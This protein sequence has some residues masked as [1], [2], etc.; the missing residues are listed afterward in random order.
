MKQFVA[1]QKINLIEWKVKTKK[2]RQKQ[3]FNKNQ[4]FP[5]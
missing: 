4:G 1:I 2:P 3:V 5:D